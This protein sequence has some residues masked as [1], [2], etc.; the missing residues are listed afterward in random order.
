MA[1][2]APS[3]KL[4]GVLLLVSVTMTLVAAYA[5]FG[6]WRSAQAPVTLDELPANDRQ[7]LVSEVQRVLPGVH[8]AAWFQPEIGYTL[9]PDAIIEAWDDVFRSNAIGYRTGPV[10]KASG[11]FRVLSIVTATLAQ[12]LQQPLALPRLRA[13]GQTEPVGP[14]DGRPVVLFGRARQR[15]SQRTC[16]LHEDAVV[17]RRQGLERSIRHLP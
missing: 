9:R 11:V 6:W 12:Q 2:P 17:E 3:P 10:N 15:R 13:A 7:R 14:V 1:R 8:Q 16:R 5:G 4:V